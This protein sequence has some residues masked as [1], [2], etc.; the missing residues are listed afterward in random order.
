MFTG[1]AAEAVQL[2]VDPEGAGAGGGEERPL[3]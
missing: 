2:A 3:R 1:R